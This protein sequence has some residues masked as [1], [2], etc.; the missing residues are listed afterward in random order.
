MKIRQKRINHIRDSMVAGEHEDS[1]LRQ[2]GAEGKS[3]MSSNTDSEKIQVVH[4]KIR[5]QDD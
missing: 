3:Q 1:L 4:L 5:V 2:R